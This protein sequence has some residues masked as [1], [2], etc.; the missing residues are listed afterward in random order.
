[1]HNLIMKAGIHMKFWPRFHHQS[2]ESQLVQA[3]FQAQMQGRKKCSRIIGR[4][5]IVTTLLIFTATSALVVDPLGFASSGLNP[6]R[7]T[8]DG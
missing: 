1:M 8:G 5:S 3:L 4:F 7:F 2:S 6:F